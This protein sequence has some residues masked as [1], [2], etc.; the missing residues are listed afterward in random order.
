MSAIQTYEVTLATPAGD[1]VIEVPTYQGAEAAARR[2]YWL[3]IARGWG[4]PDEITVTRC[5]SLPGPTTT[6]T[7]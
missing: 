3:A 4:E 5:I 6:V 2:G 7:S 1:A